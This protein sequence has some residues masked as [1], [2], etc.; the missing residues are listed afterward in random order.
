MLNKP[1]EVEPLALL[2]TFGLLMGSIV[3]VANYALSQ[4]V[5]VLTLA[6]QQFVLS[7][8]VL[9]LICVATKRLVPISKQNLTFYLVSGVLGIAGP[10]VL[11]FLVVGKLGAG[12]ASM[13]YIFPPLFTYAMALLIGMERFQGVRA[14]GLLLG[15][16]G[17]F[18]IIFAA[19][20]LG[21]DVTFFWLGLLYLIPFIMA[22]G[23]IYRALKWPTG[24]RNLEVT[25]AV[26][27]ASAILLTIPAALVNLDSLFFMQPINLTVI[28]GVQALITGAAYL[29]F[30]RLQAVG[31][32]VYLSQAGYV[33][34]GVGLLYGLTLFGE[35]FPAGVWFGFGVALCGVVTVTLH[36][37]LGTT[38]KPKSQSPS[39]QETISEF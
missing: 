25:T 34:T 18:W 27:C 16:I 38:D 8:S 10:H 12:F 20:R 9:L 35:R 7:G 1:G 31:G 6:F 36:Q 14:V 2:L 23:N 26:L 17:S 15:L 24:L 39:P 4:G 22:W 33:I 21:G 3:A 5:H 11:L 30:F 28:S 19:G 13:A 32:P 29:V 37:S